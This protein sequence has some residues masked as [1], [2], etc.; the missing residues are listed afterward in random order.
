M[1]EDHLTKT[2][3]SRL[4]SGYESLAWKGGVLYFNSN[5]ILQDVR[6]PGFDR[7]L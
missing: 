1:G 2:V 4:D 6:W 7:H 3:M 5:I